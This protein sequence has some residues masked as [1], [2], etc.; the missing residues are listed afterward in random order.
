MSIWQG[1]QEHSSAD[2]A[3]CCRDKSQAKKR[4]KPSAAGSRAQVPFSTESEACNIEQCFSLHA[5]A[6]MS[7]CSL[8][9]L[10]P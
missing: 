6:T 9:E 7:A 1:Q 3:V 8:C 5:R 2:V 4:N 10:S